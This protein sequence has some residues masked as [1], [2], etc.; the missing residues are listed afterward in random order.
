LLAA[1]AD[2]FPDQ[3]ARVCGVAGRMRG[4]R[5]LQ[6][7]I[8]EPVR[9]VGPDG[10]ET[11]PSGG[12]V[13]AG[14]Q[15]EVGTAAVID[16]DAAVIESPGISL[17]TGGT[18]ALVHH[19]HLPAAAGL[20]GAVVTL[21]VIGGTGYG[22]RSAIE[23]IAIAIV[24]AIVVPIVRATGFKGEV[25]AAAVI[26]PDA[27]I[28]ESPGISLSTRGAA[29]LVDHFHVCASAGFGVAVMTLAIIG[30]AS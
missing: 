14:L 16:P 27:A 15:G 28:I 7:L 13:R 17:R 10:T 25:S 30:R 24:V 26:D 5:D 23:I 1:A 8:H 4:R 21:T 9:L 20:H 2:F 29:A 22:A 12:T 6:T 3:D 19:L 11:R 18:A